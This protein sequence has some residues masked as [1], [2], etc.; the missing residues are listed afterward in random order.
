MTYDPR[1]SPRVLVVDKI[2]TTRDQL[3]ELLGGLASE[4]AWATR[5]AAP[6][7]LRAAVAAGQAFD[8]V[9]LEADAALTATTVR[10]LASSGGNVRV[11]LAADGDE[12]IGRAHV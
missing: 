12:E 11:V 5:D 7:R 10:E 1:V 8:V 2:A 4:V 9:I 6:D 3:A